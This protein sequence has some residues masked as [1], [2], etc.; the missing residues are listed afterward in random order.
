[1]HRCH[2][3]IKLK[4]IN[5]CGLSSMGPFSLESL[6]A[7]H[8]SGLLNVGP[9][10][11]KY[12]VQFADFPRFI[13]FSQA[14]TSSEVLDALDNLANQIELGEALIET[15]ADN[16]DDGNQAKFNYLLMLI[17]NGRLSPT[18]INIQQCPHKHRLDNHDH[19]HEF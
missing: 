4:D 16:P 12:C 17:A 5:P 7:T 1:M 19:H 18:C 3:K 14:G 15:N 8:A 13:D 11:L 10:M 6:I 2:I 9:L